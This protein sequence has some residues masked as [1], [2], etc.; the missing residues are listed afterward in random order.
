MKKL[1][2]KGAAR[3]EFERKLGFV[4]LYLEGYLGARIHDHFEDARGLRRPDKHGVTLRIV[5]TEEGDFSVESWE[6][7]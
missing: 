2:F 6:E 1:L 7:F 5:R 3:P 4:N